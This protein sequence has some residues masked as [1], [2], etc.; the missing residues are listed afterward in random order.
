MFPRLLNKLSTMPGWHLQ[1]RFHDEIKYVVYGIVLCPHVSKHFADGAAP[2]NSWSLHL[3]YQDRTTCESILL[4]PEHFDDSGAEVSELL[5]KEISRVGPSTLVRDCLRQANWT[6]DFP[7]LEEFLSHRVF[8]EGSHPSD[9]GEAE[10][11]AYLDQMV[12]THWS[13]AGELVSAHWGSDYSQ[14]LLAE[15]RSAV[16]AGIERASELECNLEFCDSYSKMR[17]TFPEFRRHVSTIEPLS[18]PAYQALF[19]KERKPTLEIVASYVHRVADSHSWYKKLPFLPPGVAFQFYLKLPGNHRPTGLN[20]YGPREDIGIMQGPS[21]QYGDTNSALCYAQVAPSLWRGAVKTEDAPEFAHLPIV[22]GRYELHRIPYEIH[23]AGQILLTSVMHEN[24]TFA[25][26][27]TWSSHVTP[28]QRRSNLKRFFPD[29]SPG[30]PAETGGHDALKLMVAA[31]SAAPPGQKLWTIPEVR[32]LLC[33]ERQRLRGLMMKYME[34]VM[35]LVWVDEGRAE[36]EYSDS[37]Y[38]AHI[39]TVRY[40]VSNE[41]A[42]RNR[43]LTALRTGFERTRALSDRMH[44]RPGLVERF[45][46]SL[47]RQAESPGKLIHVSFNSLSAAEAEVE[48][49]LRDERRQW[50]ETMN[51]VRTEWMW[52]IDQINEGAG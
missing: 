44:H 50:T 22:A 45:K 11:A 9:E 31:A 20:P 21:G 15:V 7:W 25:L 2:A 47:R 51:L 41:I 32:K 37:P 28:E 33:A 42:R 52:Q 16:A 40:V 5:R 14:A 13:I 49:V 30:W 10:Q 29:D 19:A 46:Q 43:D 48:L 38:R 12:K 6:A 17:R 35:G 36:F 3:G 39:P 26:E 8:C 23:H 4:R 24:A 1:L 34:R 18:L 27:A